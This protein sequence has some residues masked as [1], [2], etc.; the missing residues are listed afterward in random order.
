M[1]LA[2]DTEILALILLS[3]LWIPWAE[4]NLMVT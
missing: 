2:V 3:A 1:A 4:L